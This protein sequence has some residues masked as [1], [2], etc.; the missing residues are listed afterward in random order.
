MAKKQPDK[1]NW[2][3]TDMLELPKDLV[4]ELPRITLIGQRELYLE[5]HK[6]I[7]EYD[8]NQIKINL[9]RG[10]LEIEGLD[11]EIKFIIHDELSIVG[12]IKALRF[13]E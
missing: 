13:V 12:N 3:L 11:M 7:I 2:I 1:L 9:V 5:N 4:L 8:S 6:G 10:Y